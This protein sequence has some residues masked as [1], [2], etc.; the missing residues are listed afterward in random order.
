MPRAIPIRFCSRW[1]LPCRR[2]Y[3]WRGALLPH[4][5][6]LAGTNAGGMISVALSLGSPQ[7]GITRHRSSLEPGLSS[8]MQIPT[9]RRSPNPLAKVI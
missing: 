1:G 7:P 2:C 5:F 8:P 6:D 9:W 3:Q 4:R